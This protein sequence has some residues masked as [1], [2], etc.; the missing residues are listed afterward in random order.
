MKWS[1]T[2]DFSARQELKE[3]GEYIRDVLQE[4]NTAKKQ[5]Q[6]IRKA[7]NSLNHFPLRHRVYEHE[8]WRSR[9]VRVLPVDNY[10]IFYHPNES[11][12]IVTILHILY[13]PMNIPDQLDEAAE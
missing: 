5:V 2:Y 7:A 1:V 10:L 13:G 6:R 8:P 11:T 9:A 3:I 12:H 4:P